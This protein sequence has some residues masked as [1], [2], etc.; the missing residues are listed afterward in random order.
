MRE[1]LVCSFHANALKLLSAPG[2]AEGGEE[3]IC[4]FPAA[5]FTDAVAAEV[6]RRARVRERV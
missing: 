2:R 1:T 4:A 3:M 6:A 5:K